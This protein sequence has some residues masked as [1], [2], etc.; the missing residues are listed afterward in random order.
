MYSEDYPSLAFPLKCTNTFCSELS[1]FSISVILFDG[2]PE[3]TAVLLGQP[4][5]SARNKPDNQICTPKI[6]GKKVLAFSQGK[7]RSRKGDQGGQTCSCHGTS[8]S[9]RAPLEANMVCSLLRRAFATKRPGLPRS[10]SSAHLRRSTLTCKSPPSIS[11]S[12]NQEGP[13]RCGCSAHLSRTTL[14]CKF[15]ALSCHQ[16]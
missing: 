16:N 10:G 11:P 12:N 3:G 6:R 5:C 1:D 13:R 4:S 9:S 14:T 8:G 15:P 7:E 2:S